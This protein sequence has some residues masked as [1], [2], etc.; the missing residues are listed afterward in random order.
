[1]HRLSSLSLTAQFLALSFLTLA[2]QASHV[3]PLQIK[4]DKGTVE[5]TLTNGQKIRA[6]KGIPF[7]APPIGNLRWQPPQPAAKWKGV[8]PAKDF[9]SHCI[10]SSG[11]PDMVFHDP[12][13]SE[14]CLT[15][16]V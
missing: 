16:N 2:A 9:G 5:G 11:Y 8:R 7:A 1:M 3:D 14:D 12:G 6:F 4:T 15:L 10:Q 13:P